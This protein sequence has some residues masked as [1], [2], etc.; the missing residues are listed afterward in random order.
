MNREALEILAKQDPIVSDSSATTALKG[1]SHC[2]FCNAGGLFSIYRGREWTHNE[3][4]P[5]TQALEELIRM[6]A[7]SPDLS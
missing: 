6:N 4:C 2:K 3:N 5:W 7:I 1:Y